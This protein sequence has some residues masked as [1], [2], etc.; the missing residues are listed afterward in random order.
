[1]V[2]DHLLFIGN[3][4][5]I[6]TPYPTSLNDGSL[7]KNTY[8]PTYTREDTGFD[9][10]IKILFIVY[11][12]HRAERGHSKQLSDLVLHTHTHFCTIHH[13]N[14]IRLKNIRKYVY[15]LSFVCV[16]VCCLDQ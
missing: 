5:Y 9:K 15:F 2:D 11:K 8:S 6:P 4:L 1:M 14:Q 12:T 3:D 7:H 10:V 13:L 16:C